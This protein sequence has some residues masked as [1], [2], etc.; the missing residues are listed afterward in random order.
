MCE[1]VRLLY[2][3]GTVAP[4]MGDKNRKNP[5]VVRIE[6]GDACRGVA[7]RLLLPSWLQGTGDAQR[8]F[9][10]LAN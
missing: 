3:L 8:S 5:P 9:L 6:N 1:Y 4:R 2:K 7:D 10:A